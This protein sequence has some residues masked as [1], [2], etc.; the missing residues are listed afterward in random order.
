MLKYYNID[1]YK[2][3]T[4]DVIVYD[5]HKKSGVIDIRF[6]QNKS[7]QKILKE[8]HVQIATKK[9]CK[10]IIK[11]LVQAINENKPVIVTYDPYYNPAR[12]DAYHK[13]H[14]NHSILVNGYNL[15]KRVIYA[16]EH[17]QWENLNYE[18]SS[19]PFDTFKLCYEKGIENYDNPF[20]FFVIVEES[21]ISVDKKIL[22]NIL[23]NNVKKYEDVLNEGINSLRDFILDYSNTVK[24]KELLNKRMSA[25]INALNSIINSKQA[26]R[27]RIKYFFGETSSLWSCINNII[28]SYIK[29]RVYLVR[30]SFSNVYREDDLN[31][32]ILELE[33]ILDQESC[34]LVSIL[35][36]C[37]YTTL[38]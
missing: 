18:Q 36:K 17:K 33:K 30:Y 37:D 15:D 14:F 4:E 1:I 29:V 10:N 20:T 22:Q 2:Y 23:L 26:E 16:L 12:N 3:M 5:Y 24:N 38:K 19:I 27:Y 21:S 6:I 11:K 31:K 8:D 13:L 35:S 32:S 28:K 25:Y 7:L 34:Y 9:T